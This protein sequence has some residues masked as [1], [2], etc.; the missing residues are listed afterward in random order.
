M[1]DLKL[2]ESTPAG[3]LDEFSAVYELIAV[4][5]GECELVGHDDGGMTIDKLYRAEHI[6]W[7]PPLLSF[8]IERHG[9]IV[10]GR[11]KKAEYQVWTFNVPERTKTWSSD[12]YR[13]VEPLEPRIKVAPLAEE[14]A[15]LVANRQ[16][17]P[18]LIWVPNGEVRI[19]IALVPGLGNTNEHGRTLAK[20]TIDGRR[21]R[22][23]KAFE[24]I[25]LPRGW[26]RVRAN[27]YAPP[28]DTQ[29]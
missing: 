13:L 2:L 24:S 14:Y 3:P 26:S 5:W 18:T 22:F 11:S 25:L 9:A 16:P 20:E 10:G 23:R 17:H 15:D 8:R 12:G 19:N 7:E 4:L 6:S 27:V 1:T 29:H 21:R 28:A